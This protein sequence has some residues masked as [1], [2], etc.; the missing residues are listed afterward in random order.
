MLQLFDLHCD[1]IERY[2]ESGTDF[3]SPNTHFSLHQLGEFDRLCQTFAIFIPDT[4]R[5]DEAFHYF[6]AHRLY[7]MELL[8]QQSSLVAMAHHASDIR[9]ITEQGKCAV[10]LSVEGGAVLGGKI[11]RIAYLQQCGV[12]MFTLVW[13]GENEIGSGSATEKGLTPFGKRVV[14]ELET[15][16]IT[17]D[18]SHLNDR[19]FD[20]LCGVATQPFIATHSNLRSV[21]NHP[22]NLREDQFVEIVRRKGLVGLNL[23]QEFIS[24]EKQGGTMENLY[25]HIDRMLELGGEDVIAC[26]SDF[27]GADIHPTLA[28]PVAW[29]RGAEYLLERGIPERV[30]R[31]IYFENALRF[32]E[33]L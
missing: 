4:I 31:K 11:E 9:R 12:K 7:L 13:N 1:S 21:C 3:L 15:H 16:A 20:D 10:I 25:R 30:V 26:G 24:L 32:F 28:N 27:D 5:G 6:E 19:G 8:K 17:V 29:A 2:K 22:R 18:V 14:S 23:F 33:G